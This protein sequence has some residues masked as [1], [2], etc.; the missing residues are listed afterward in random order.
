M[1]EDKQ[2][3]KIR[4]L[5]ERFESDNGV[6]GNPLKVVKMKDYAIG[7]IATGFE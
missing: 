1:G 6:I 2:D 3:G 4:V 7:N 5:Q